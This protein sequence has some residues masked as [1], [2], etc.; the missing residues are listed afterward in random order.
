MP[1]AVCGSLLLQLYQWIS[2]ARQT[3]SI[4]A[5]SNSGI[6]LALAAAYSKTPALFPNSPKRDN[7]VDG[8][9]LNGGTKYMVA[10][11]YK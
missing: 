10:R 9:R 5:T 6:V 11:K 7:P 4:I 8:D 3:R 1:A 2:A